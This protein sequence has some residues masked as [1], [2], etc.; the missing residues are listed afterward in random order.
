M[1][2][3]PFPLGHNSISL[4]EHRFIPLARI[5]IILK[6]YLMDGRSSYIL[7]GWTSLNMPEICLR[8]MALD[9]KNGVGGSEKNRT[10]GRGTPFT[11]IRLA[12]TRDTCAT[13]TQPG[14]PR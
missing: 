14:A 2:I 3:F 8:A 11:S 1:P 10:Q 7:A 5:F 6:R 12:A 13:V 4:I 9:R